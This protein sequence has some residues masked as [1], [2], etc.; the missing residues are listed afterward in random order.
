[1]E[2]NWLFQI[3]TGYYN[4]IFLISVVLSLACACVCF[5]E[6]ETTEKW[7]AAYVANEVKDL[8]GH[9]FIL[10][11]FTNLVNIRWSFFIDD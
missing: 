5:L 9:E 2:Y 1:M 3:I 7:S 8:A 4:W 6:L 10:Q 11:V